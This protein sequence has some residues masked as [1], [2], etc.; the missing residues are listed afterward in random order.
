MTSK[1]NPPE[2]LKAFLRLVVNAQYLEEIEGDLEELYHERLRTKGRLQ[3]N[4]LY[5]KDVLET[6]RPYGVRNSGLKIRSNQSAYVSIL[7]TNLKLSLRSLWKRKGFT[8]INV[9]GLAIGV[10]SCMMLTFFILDELSFDK[11]FADGDRIYRLLLER[12]EPEATGVVGV[13]PHSFAAVIPKDCHE[14]ER[15]ATLVGPFDDTM[16]EYKDAKQT[17]RKVLE[18]DVFAADS[19]FFKI[20]SFQIFKGDRNTM[21]KEP[22]SMV[23]TKS[24]AERHFGTADPLGKIVSMSGD[25]FVVTGVCEDPPANTHF[26]FNI[27]ISIHT[28]ERFT[29]QN[30]NRV[31]SYCYLKLKP[32]ADPQVLESKFPALVNLYAAADF[33]KLNN[34]SWADHVKAGF[35]FRYFL[36]PLSYVYLHPDNISDF[37]PAGN[38][39]M[40]RIL[41]AIDVLIFLIACIN[42]INLATARS[43]ERA[44][45]VGIRKVV[46]SHKISLVFQFLTESFLVAATAV[47]IAVALVYISL[48]I[49]NM[50]AGKTFH[51]TFNL[52]F[53]LI[54]GL[55][56][57]TV[58]L[59]AGLYPAFVLSSFK[60]IVVLKG[61]FTS[62]GKGRWIRSGLVVFQFSTA[63]MLIIGTMMIYKQM[64]FIQEKDLG[65]DKEQ[66]LLITGDFHMKPHFA[67][68]FVDAL[69]QLP[70]VSAC[71]GSLSMPSSDGVYR[72][73]Y[74]A[75]TMPDIQPFHTMI[76]GDNYAEV[77]GFKK[78]AGELFSESTN[79]S[80]SVVL[81]EA[82]VK[83]FGFDDPVGKTITYIEQ[84]YGTGQ[85]TNYKVIGV[86]KDFNFTSLHLNIM[87]LVIQSNEIIFSR[88][89]NIVARLHSNTERKAL[90]S[91]GATW[92]KLAPDAPFEYKFMSHIVEAHYNKERQIEGIITIFSVLSILVACIGL[93]GLSAYTVSLRTKEIGIRKVTGA[94]SVDIIKLLLKDSLKPICISFLIAAPLGWYLIENWWFPQFAFR[95][96]ISIWSF[97]LVGASMVV[98]ALLTTGF[99]SIK[100]A[101]TSPVDAIR[102]N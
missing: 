64:K 86:V 92:K 41:I 101:L 70:E 93:F 80:L 55:L 54:V 34:S 62:T 17:D 60:P 20:L 35:G 88:M 67:K 36:C 56:T 23:L 18:Q 25:D 28:I 11:S 13:V 72:Q 48:P 5:A 78:I 57:L 89:G 42:F 6:I 32:D 7:A 51:L 85:Q 30:F 33:E 61:R 9:A 4:F 91:I 24:T 66:L 44:K 40:I 49:F 102:Q 98:I 90:E 73:Q 8:L 45:E 63:I 97:L 68:T 79:D 65:Y 74:R 87:P 15:A 27:I 69:K 81:N 100:A 31:N 58:A 94:V 50:V 1:K 71:A 59:L 46:G 26:K 29:R 21:L 10:A 99:Q 96:E 2:L 19:N 82:A 14:V 12:K 38:I 3:A 39:V 43:S 75:E 47:V 52:Q 95:T 37:K 53:L 76:V 77:M 83:A 22:R 84:T 16:I